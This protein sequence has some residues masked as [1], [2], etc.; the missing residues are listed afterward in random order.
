MKSLSYWRLN[1]RSF[2]LACTMMEDYNYYNFRC[3][4]RRA[5]VRTFR[6]WT[7]VA[8][9]SATTASQSFL[10]PPPR[11]IKALKINVF[12]Q[13]SGSN[14]GTSN[15]KIEAWRVKWGYP[16]CTSWSQ[17]CYCVKFSDNAAPIPEG[18]TAGLIKGLQRGTVPEGSE[19]RV[20]NAWLSC[21]IGH[22]DWKLSD[23][24]KLCIWNKHSF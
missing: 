18:I 1:W 16:C 9:P 20:S 13:T 2:Y 10:W 24:F 21:F 7:R 8:W 11:T 22:Y 15:S 5:P 17:L 4:R 23:A 19:Q 12:Q 3:V 14:R 6:H